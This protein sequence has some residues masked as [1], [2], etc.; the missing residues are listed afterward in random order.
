MDDKN[1]SLIISIVKELYELPSEN[2]A[3]D[4]ISPSFINNCLKEIESCLVSIGK[5]AVPHLIGLL[6]R[7]KLPSC[8]RAAEI[9]GRI[10]DPEA[11]PA[12]ACALL[13]EDLGEAAGKV[14]QKLG[15]QTVPHIIDIVRSAITPDSRQKAPPKKDLSYALITLGAIRCDESCLFL[16]SLLDDYIAALPPGPFDTEKYEWPFRNIEF[17]LLLD[18][19]VKQQDKRA[20]PHVQRSMQAFKPE[21]IDH[22]VCRIAIGRIKK[23]QPDGY[24]PMEA[25]ELT[26]PFASIMSAFSSEDYNHDEDIEHTYGDLLRA[27][28]EDKND[29]DSQPD[30]DDSLPSIEEGI[31]LATID[32][33]IDR[34]TSTITIEYVI[35]DHTIEEMLTVPRRRPFTHVFQFKLN[36]HGV[37][38]AP[39]RRLLIPESFTFYD[40]HVAIQ[41]AMNWLDYHLHHFEIPAADPSSGCAV[42]IECP[43]VEPWDRDEDWLITTEA[44]LRDYFIESKDRALYRYDYGD[45]WEVDILLEDILPRQKK[46]LYPNCLGGAL[47]GPPEDC[48]GIKGY[49][50]CIRT[51][52]A[53][54]KLDLG[55]PIRLDKD[56]EDS[57]VWLGNW[58]PDYFNPRLITFEK[59]RSRFKKALG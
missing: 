40:F 20:V 7:G 46:I 33:L 4:S 56:K 47:A 28:D 8:I 51:A 26:L 11:V 44:K 3:A 31:E 35:G 36:L 21:Y 6:N 14:L 16:N 5:P 9:L 25:L 48:G 13:H 57:L 34:Y 17:Y 18:A 58:N 10:G 41:D 23:K 27:A 19:M 54:S 39:W 42:H 22:L 49:R 38:P 59:P 12:L 24:L 55:K 2:S 53:A 29:S 50:E 30:K 45:C 32:E 37:R 43:W 1:H 15:P 52:R